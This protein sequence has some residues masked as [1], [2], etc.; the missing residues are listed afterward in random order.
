MMEAGRWD[1]ARAVLERAVD[2]PGLEAGASALLAEIANEQEDWETGLR[3]GKRAVAADA[4]S[5]NAQ[6][7]YA[8]ALRT[9]MQKVSQ[10]RAM[11][12]LGDYKKA[13][14]RAIEL[15]GS[16]LAAREEQIGFFLEAPGIAGGSVD[17]ARELATELRGVDWRGGTIMLAR[18]ETKAKNAPAASKLYGELLERHPDDAPAR[19]ALGYSLQ[20][21]E[22]WREA[23]AEFERLSAV[24]GPTGLGA[25][26][27]RG[28]TRILGK[29]EQEQA[30][31]FL[32]S[33]LERADPAGQP[34]PSA[35]WWRIGNAY[36]QLQ[37]VEDA[38]AAY[39]EAL[40]LDAKNDEAKEALAALK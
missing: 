29:Y 11:M 9:K 35:V 8:V 10:V 25:L 3:W 15:D 31:A 38:R 4:Q 34:A 30:V 33:Y 12:S 14:S 26:Y 1:D 24:E 23:D 28:R 13:L 32:Q 7:Q 19:F 5:S 2:Q 20:A 21:E 39:R 17:K 22:R 27:Q 36:E 18:V 37:R 6:Y 16:N 40:R